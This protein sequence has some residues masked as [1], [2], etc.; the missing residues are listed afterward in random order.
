M[1]VDELSPK[2]EIPL[3]LER[4]G[5]NTG[6]SSNETGVNDSSSLA[7]VAESEQGET[8]KEEDMEISRSIDDI[9]DALKKGLNLDEKGNDIEDEKIECEDNGGN[10]KEEIQMMKGEG[11]EMIEINQEV[12]QET[13]EAEKQEVK[14]EDK[15]EETQSVDQGEADVAR[16]NVDQVNGQQ[17]GDENN[18]KQEKTQE[19]TA[20]DTLEG[21]GKSIEGEAQADED[22]AQEGTHG[23]TKK[24]IEEMNHELEKETNEAGDNIGKDTESE[25]KCDTD[26]DGTED[27]DEEVTER[28]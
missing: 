17:K 23:V 16:E 19:E 6:S 18:E 21:T 14:M 4:G 26:D 25:E 20:K 28:K 13:S 5:G 27:E 1:S 11:K 15:E 9:V 10:K 3:K 22:M 8:R 24:D 12:R 7:D 2:E